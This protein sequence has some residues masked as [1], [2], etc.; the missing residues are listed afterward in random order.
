M[1]VLKVANPRGVATKTFSIEAMVRGYPVHQDSW[2]AAIAEQLP[3]KGTA[4][5]PGFTVAVVRSSVTIGHVR[6]KTL[7]V[8][9]MLVLH[10]GTIHCRVIAPRRY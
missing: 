8:W 7:S 2:D 5:I 4:I 6:K 10:G 9:S 1:H 3:C